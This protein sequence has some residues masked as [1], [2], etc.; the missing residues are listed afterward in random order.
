MSLPGIQREGILV[1]TDA[2]GPLGVFNCWRAI[3]IFSRTTPVPGNFQRVFHVDLGRPALL[4]GQSTW[5]CSLPRH[6]YKSDRKEKCA[7]DSASETARYIEEGRLCPDVFYYSHYIQTSA[8]RLTGW[9]SGSFSHLG[10]GEGSLG[11]G[12]V[13]GLSSGPKGFEVVRGERAAPIMNVRSPSC[14]RLD[15][16]DLLDFLD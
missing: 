12:R 1:R 3:S 7:L 13:P 2:D 9:V 11:K 8:L 4:M 5:F 6:G 14:Q 15:G 10:F 16:S